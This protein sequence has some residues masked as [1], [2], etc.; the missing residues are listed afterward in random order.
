MSPSQFRYPECAMQFQERSAGS[1][2]TLTGISGRM[3]IG[4][5]LQALEQS[6]ATWLA[7]GRR[8]IVFDLSQV[9]YMDSAGLGILLASSSKFSQAGGGI[10]VAGAAPKVLHMLQLTGTAEI[11]NLFDSADA[12]LAGWSA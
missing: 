7:E 12:A 4:P 1:D 9:E 2:V 8:K 3:T 11:L 10:R 5:E 6:I